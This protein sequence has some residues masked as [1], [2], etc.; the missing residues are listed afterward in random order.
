[1]KQFYAD[2]AWQQAESLLSIDS[3][4]GF[5]S[6]A[7]QWVKDAFSSLGFPVHIT[8]KGGILAD[9]GGSDA[10]DALL[11]SAHT[12][13]LGGMVAQIKGNGRLKLTNLGGMRPE[14]GEAENVRV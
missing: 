9:L 11:L 10:N 5:T 14:N 13:T 2:Y 8:Q 3:P 6:Q 4:S 12:D 1:M 7:A